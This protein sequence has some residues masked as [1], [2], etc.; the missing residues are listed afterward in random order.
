MLFSD[1]LTFC[2]VM[3]EECL[4]PYRLVLERIN[5]F[6][7]HTLSQPEENL[8]AMQGE[9]AQTANKAFRQL[10]DADLKFGEVVNEKGIAV[11]LTN[12]SFSSFLLS[13]NRDVRKKAFHQYYHQFQSHENTLAATLGRSGRAQV[14]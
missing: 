14:R 4:S 5:R 9:M 12:A 1:S 6:R 7:K 10:N 3:A 13:P 2:V 11:E 8:L